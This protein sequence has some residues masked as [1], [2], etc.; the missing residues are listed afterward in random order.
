MFCK[1]TA[2]QIQTKYGVR[3]SVT[4]IG[5]AL[6]A[7][8]RHQ[9]PSECPSYIPKRTETRQARHEHGVHVE[10]LKN[11]LRHAL[12]GC[13]GVRKSFREHNRMVTSRSTKFVVERVTPDFLHVVPIRE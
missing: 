8:H 12:S 2:S 5:G 13:H 10:N 6:F 7:V 4:V 9:N 3:Q 11:D 1:I